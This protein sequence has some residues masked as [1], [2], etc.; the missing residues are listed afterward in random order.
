MF[1]KWKVWWRVCR[2]KGHDWFVESMTLGGVWIRCG[3]CRHLDEFLPGLNEPKGAERVYQ[4]WL[5]N[6]KRKPNLR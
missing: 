6:V 4:D 1:R 5:H 2:K 3:R